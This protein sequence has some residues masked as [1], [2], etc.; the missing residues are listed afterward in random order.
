VDWSEGRSARKLNGF[1]FSRQGF[2]GQSA[3]Q[4]RG[5]PNALLGVCSCLVGRKFEVGAKQA[6]RELSVLTARCLVE[7]V[8]KPKPGRYVLKTRAAGK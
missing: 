4:R 7:F 5:F 1:L 6:K 2:I 8:R 3:V